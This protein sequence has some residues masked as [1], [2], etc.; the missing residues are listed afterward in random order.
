MSLIN[1]MFTSLGFAS[2]ALKPKVDDVNPQMGVMVAGLFQQMTAKRNLNVVVET[3]S[4]FAKAS[5]SF[6]KKTKDVE[7]ASNTANATRLAAN[8][9]TK[10]LEDLK[11]RQNSG[12]QGLENEISNS[13]L[14]LTELLDALED[15]NS[16]L[17]REEEEQ[18][19]A[20]AYFDACK[21]KSDLADKLY[22]QA[23][24]AVPTVL[25]YMD[26]AAAGNGLIDMEPEQ[27]ESL[28]NNRLAESIAAAMLGAV[29]GVNQ[30]K[31]SDL[32]QK[33]IDKASGKPTSL[34][35]RTKALLG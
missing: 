30:P 24:G 27:Q 14:A 25:S 19:E 31:L 3:G 32:A 6:K 10:E 11:A 2:K 20:Q 33:A 9:T 8:N 13:E 23:H 12:E 28:R 18:V 4:A 34:E 1:N 21:K 17:T 16:K 15:A 5:E 22:R 26:I 29:K 35:E 7:L